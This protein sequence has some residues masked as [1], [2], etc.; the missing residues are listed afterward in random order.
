MKYKGQKDVAYKLGQVFGKELTSSGIASMYDIITAVPLHNSRLRQ[1]GYNQ[2]D[3]WALGISDSTNIEFV[4]N[5]LSRRF[6]TTTQTK[7]TRARRWEN[8][9]EVFFAKEPES[10]K[11]K[12][13]LLVDDV[14]TTGSTLESCS[15]A[16][17]NG[18]C[19][20]VGVACI[21]SAV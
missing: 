9:K 19:D 15:Q 3:E 21:A 2:S 7:M 14:V 16:L 10:I 17:L 5:V 18:G 8:V 6:K 20:S 13:V 1:R 12:R 4:P 11:G